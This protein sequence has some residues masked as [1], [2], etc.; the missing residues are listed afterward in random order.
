MGRSSKRKRSLSS[1]GAG[2][3]ASAAVGP[4]TLDLPRGEGGTTI[5]ALPA[6]T[7]LAVFAHLECPARQHAACVC[8]RWREALLDA[9]FCRRVA[10][11]QC[12]S[13]ALQL[14]RSGDTLICAPGMYQETLLVEVPLRLVAED[15]WAWERERDRERRW[16]RRLQQQ[17]QQ[18]ERQQQQGRVSGGGGAGAG[19]AAGARHGDAA[20]AA[21]AAA[22]GAGGISGSGSGRVV[23]GAGG[24]GAVLPRGAPLVGGRPAPSV[25]VIALR[26]PVA[27]MNSRCCFVGFEFHTGT[28]HNEVSICCFGPEGDAARFELCTFS[29]LTGLRVPYSKGP[30]TRLELHDCSLIG[31]TQTLAAVQMDAGRL[32]MD[33]C[34][35][36]NNSVGVE[37]GPAALARL[38]RCDV[39]WCGTALVVDGCLALAHC[40][41][42]GNGKVGNVS[43]DARVRSA[44]QE[45]AQLLAAVPAEGGAAA[46]AAA[47]AAD[48]SLP[49]LEDGAG[50]SA[51]AGPAGTGGVAAA[52]AA[53]G[54]QRRTG[55]RT[56]RAAAAAA[57]VAGAA[58]GPGP[59]S[60]AAAA[61][62]A[63]AAAASPTRGT[64]LS[65]RR[66]ASPFSPILAGGAVAVAST[67]TAAEPGA[68]PSAGAGRGAGGSA[69][70]G[71]GGG[72]PRAPPRAQVEA[73]AAAGWAE[74]AAA[75]AARGSLVRVVDSEVAAPQL[76]MRAGLHKDVRK[77]ARQL[78]RQ[79]YGSLDDEAAPEWEVLV[80]SD[81]DSDGDDPE[82]DPDVEDPDE[83]ELAAAAEEDDDMLADMMGDPLD[84]A[85]DPELDESGEG[86][87]EDE[88]SSGSSRSGGSSGSGSGSGGSGSEEGEGEGEGSEGGG[89][90]GAGE[91]AGAAGAAGEEGEGGE[92]GEGEGEGEGED[93][94]WDG[95]EESSG[96]SGGSSSSGGGSSSSDEGE[97]SSDDSD[98]E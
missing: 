7:L 47:A 13:E 84:A 80:A 54:R 88:D 91:G 55:A 71:G 92:A 1:G 76:I 96:G 94:D 78:V 85:D 41:L 39:R 36:Q 46:A 8:R 28:A 42:W 11:G 82:D 89:C 68:G 29:G 18:Q 81:L 64:R 90:E 67:S 79:V 50:G 38:A 24:A 70:G 43:T 61:A 45:S 37:V 10:P 86:E 3:S 34:V 53:G 32:H 22:S 25:T 51:A 59:S 21:T 98:D 33:R 26:P 31:T 69:A 97:S 72:G 58:A 17:E 30:D 35:V 83:L 52:G 65:A 60:A 48:G 93:E 74:V 49:Q 56:Q 20:P 15:H 16:Q 19:G 14:C 95:G 73:L 9:A 40:R 27:V 4:Q 75:F 12:L 44:M 2:P 5:D 63:L 87:G 57:D 6:E 77:K 66:G 62:A 23:G